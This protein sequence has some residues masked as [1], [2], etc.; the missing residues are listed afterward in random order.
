MTII[1]PYRDGHVQLDNVTCHRNLLDSKWFEKHQ[2]EFNLLP[3][4]VWSPDSDPIEHVWGKVERSLLSI[5]T[6]VIIDQHSTAT[7]S[8]TC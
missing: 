5:P 4:P 6:V 3:W 1:F 7:V 8:P 2:S